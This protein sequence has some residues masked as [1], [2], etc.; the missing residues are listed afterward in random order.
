M[1]CCAEYLV[2]LCKLF[3]NIKSWGKNCSNVSFEV[4]FFNNLLLHFFYSLT[5]YMKHKKT[6]HYT[7][8]VTTQKHSNFQQPNSANDYDY[9]YGGGD[10]RNSACEL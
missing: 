10:G 2:Y 9:N 4:I 5:Q 7:Q 1:Q 8:Y 3:K 6:C